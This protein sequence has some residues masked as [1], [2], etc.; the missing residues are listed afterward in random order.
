[1]LWNG[2]LAYLIRRGAIDRDWIAAHVSGFEDA[3]RG[4]AGGAPTIAAAAAADCGVEPDD[5]QRFYDLFAAT[6][7]GR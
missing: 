5:L 3:G 6:P 2:L 4:A 7:N 1:M